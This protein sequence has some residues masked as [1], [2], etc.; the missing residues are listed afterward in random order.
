MGTRVGIGIIGVGAAGIRHARACLQIPIWFADSTVDPV[1]V[2]CADACGPLAERVAGQLGFERWT[3]DWRSVVNDPRVDAVAI[4]TPN[5]THVEIVSAAAAAGKAILCEKP[6]GAEPAETAAVARVIRDTGAVFMTGY[7]YRCVPVLDHLHKVIRR[8]DLGELT[9]YRGRY[10]TGERIGKPF[11][12]AWRHRQAESGFGALSDLMSHTI[13]MAHFLFGPIAETVAN[14]ETFVGERLLDGEGS[15]DGAM[16]VVENEDYVGA[17]VRFDNGAHGTLEV[18]RVIKGPTNELSFE[19]NGSE[20]SAKWSLE[21]M[22]ELWL[23]QRSELGEGYGQVYSQ[24]SYGQHGAF[25]PGA[26]I[27]PGLMD[28]KVIEFHNFLQAATG[29]KQTTPGIAEALAVAGVQD[30][31]ARSWQ[32]S[33]WERVR[34]LA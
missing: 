23:Y 2:V 13:D 14:R 15:E 5:R 26:G 27:G 34:P 24:P 20:G 1:P 4:A 22:H 30:A 16:G 18:C 11:P 19:L 28:L 17:L 6:V 10:F 32:S 33:A 3:D 25:N 31:I 9:H 29:H 12:Y 8:G 21:R 7:N